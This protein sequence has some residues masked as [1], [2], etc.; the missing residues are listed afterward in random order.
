ML[1][2][3]WLVGS[4]GPCRQEDRQRHLGD[5]SCLME[6]VNSAEN[7]RTAYVA[8]FNTERWAGGDGCGWGVSG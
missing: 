1:L 7:N 4:A 8:E 2:R 5:H 6:G 3:S